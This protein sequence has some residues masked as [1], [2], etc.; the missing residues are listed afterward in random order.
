MNVLEMLD[1]VYY[2]GDYQDTSCILMYNFFFNR[3]VDLADIAEPGFYSPEELDI[4]F[5]G[6]V[7]RV[8][9]EFAVGVVNDSHSSLHVDA[10]YF[11]TGVHTQCKPNN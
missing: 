2:Q 4:V 8:T 9:L 11:G 3:T 1:R 7:F 5:W 6:C 10:V